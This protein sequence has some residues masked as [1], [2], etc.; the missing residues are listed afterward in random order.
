M[1]AP[2]DDPTGDWTLRRG[3][4]RSSHQSR[5]FARHN[6]R[7]G[8]CSTVAPHDGPGPVR[9]QCSAFATRDGPAPVMLDV[10]DVSV[11]QGSIH[12][13]VCSCC[14]GGCEWG[15]YQ[16]RPC[17]SCQ[18]C[19]DLGLYG[20]YPDHGWSLQLLCCLPGFFKCAYAT[21]FITCGC[22][23]ALR[24]RQEKA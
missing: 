23:L 2:R 13:N 5:T 22:S 12:F 24:R 7:P 18:Q 14:T 4:A 8:C 20:H 10:A 19:R 9:G 11:L 6:S 1:V 15:P 16:C 21:A 17:F 3:M